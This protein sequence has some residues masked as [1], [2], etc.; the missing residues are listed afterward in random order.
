MDAR[1]VAASVSLSRST[2]VALLASATL[3]AVACSSASKDAVAPGPIDGIDAS[4]DAAPASEASAD[5]ADAAPTSAEIDAACSA[6]A[7]KFCAKLNTC[8]PFELATRFESVAICAT[9]TALLCGDQLRS[10]AGTLTPAWQ[11]SCTAALDGFDCHLFGT[12]GYL[13]DACKPTPGKTAATGSC[14]Y[15]SD[16]TSGFCEHIAGG[17][18]PGCGVCAAAPPA[19]GA[20]CAGTNKTECGLG[21]TCT[22]KKCVRAAG[23]G[24]RC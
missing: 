13:P 18:A 9:R 20:D 24:S 6:Y 1:S 16:C 4:A 7:T 14:A 21:L 3:A 12:A 2:L 10:P 17:K 5:A 23:G 11:T 19:P 15:G 22:S 8:F